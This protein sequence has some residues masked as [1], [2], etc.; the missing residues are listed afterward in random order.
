MDA[1]KLNSDEKQVFLCTFIANILKTYQ[2]NV[3]FILEH[4][5]QVVFWTW[6]T[7]LDSHIMMKMK[8]KYHE[9]SLDFFDF[10][11]LYFAQDHWV[12]SS[13]HTQCISDLQ[14][15]ISFLF[16]FWDIWEIRFD[17][18]AILQEKLA[19]EEKE[20][21]KSQDHL[22][23]SFPLASWR[24]C[25]KIYE[26]SEIIEFLS[27]CDFFYW[28]LTPFCITYFIQTV[29]ES[30]IWTEIFKNEII[31]SQIDISFRWF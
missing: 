4:T 12:K 14:W 13:V 24:R 2:S 5:N 11:K 28:E 10:Y 3:V 22:E 29:V 30:E 17:L 21:I 7:V 18:I 15:R 20:H 9:A 23:I 27:W 19:H 26:K 25:Y 31:S 1:L 6:E 16:S 8:E